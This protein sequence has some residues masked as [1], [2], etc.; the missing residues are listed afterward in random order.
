MTSTA[1]WATYVVKGIEHIQM[2]IVNGTSTSSSL[3]LLFQETCHLLG[4]CSVLGSFE[5]CFT[6]LYV[7]REQEIWI[8]KPGSG[9][10]LVYSLEGWM[11]KVCLNLD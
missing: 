3:E 5:L 4:K 9:C 7:I 8:P 1:N 2:L 10:D 11:D 6:S